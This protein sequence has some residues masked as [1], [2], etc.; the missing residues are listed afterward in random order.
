[1]P[2]PFEKTSVA[3]NLHPSG[4]Y[5]VVFLR[6]IKSSIGF[7]DGRLDKMKERNFFRCRF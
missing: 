4:C 2:V 7:P 5:G 1:M 6:W 3:D